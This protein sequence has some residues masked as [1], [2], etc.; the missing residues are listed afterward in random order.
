MDERP[1]RRQTS[2]ALY[3]GHDDRHDGENTFIVSDLESGLQAFTVFQYLSTL[4][5]YVAQSVRARHS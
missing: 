5:G 2:A 1:I 4:S 3:G